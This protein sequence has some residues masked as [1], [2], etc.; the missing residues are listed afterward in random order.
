MLHGLGGQRERIQ[1]AAA[2]HLEHARAGD[3]GFVASE[4]LE[5]A[6]GLGQQ[7]HSRGFVVAVA[8]LR[9]R[10]MTG[11]KREDLLAEPLDHAKADAV[12]PGKEAHPVGHRT[13][14][15]ESASANTRQLA[16]R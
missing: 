5:P 16:T 6:L 7:L 8:P 4:L 2:A 10:T 1:T 3:L 12:V 11:T 15:A 13:A 9:A 14:G